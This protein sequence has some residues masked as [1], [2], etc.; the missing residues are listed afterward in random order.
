MNLINRCL[1]KLKDFEVH[2]K[3]RG[4]V[5][6]KNMRCVQTMR[7]FTDNFSGSTGIPVG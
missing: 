2:G 3:E 5:E 6:I 4:E 1:K 7:S